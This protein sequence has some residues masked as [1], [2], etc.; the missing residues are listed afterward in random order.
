MKADDFAQF[1]LKLDRNKASIGPKSRNT[2]VWE[3]NQSTA[4]THAESD[5]TV[6]MYSFTSYP[7]LREIPEVGALMTP[8]HWDGSWQWD[9]K[10]QWG[11]G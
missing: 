11:E 6:F 4:E 2:P 7:Y 3:I 5:V 9:G 10:A 8:V 1:L